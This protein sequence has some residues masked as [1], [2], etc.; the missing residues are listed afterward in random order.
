[1]MEQNDDEKLANLLSMGFA[2]QD[3]QEALR[4]YHGNLDHA[5][6]AL[7]SPP[8]DVDDTIVGTT[9]NTTTIHCE[10]SQ[11]SFPHGASACTC[12]ALSAAVSVLTELERVDSR[13]DDDAVMVVTPAL[14]RR[15]L[16]TGVETYA[17]LP[18]SS[19]EHRSVEEVLSCASSHRLTAVG[20]VRRGVLGSPTLGLRTLLAQCHANA[21]RWTAV[22]V[23]K[24]PETVV[25][26][27]PPR[28]NASWLLVDSH[29][30]PHLGAHG[31]YA[32]VC[33]DLT[34]LINAL[35]AVF[36]TTELGDDVGDV[37]AELYNSFDLSTFQLLPEAE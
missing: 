19:V 10:L 7:L 11:F 36:P 25:V 16:T 23:T 26:F 32:T 35:E 27:L 20:G 6:Q 31:A 3:A 28:A 37:L 8:R 2:E 9:T 12:I 14:L 15:V 24:P 5:I 18:T 17:S 4:C 22:V 29:P 34:S 30:R 21:D 33:P 13:N 1:M